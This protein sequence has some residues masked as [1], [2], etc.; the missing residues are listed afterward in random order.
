[1]KLAPQ[2][3]ISLGYICDSSDITDKADTQLESS[4]QT[5]WGQ[6]VQRYV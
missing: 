1:M 3:V 2:S 6:E 4:K 5:L